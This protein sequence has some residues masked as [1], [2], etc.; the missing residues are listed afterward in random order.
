MLAKRWNRAFCP[1]SFVFGR[2]DSGECDY[3]R[4]LRNRTDFNPPRTQNRR[5]DSPSGQ[6]KSARGLPIYG[7]LKPAKRDGKNRVRIQIRQTPEKPF[8]VNT[9]LSYARAVDILFEEDA[10]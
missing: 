9:C 7:K 6:G 1:P 8:R 4:L 10:N 2:G 3:S 5:L